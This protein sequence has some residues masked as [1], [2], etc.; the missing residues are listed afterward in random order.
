MRHFRRGAASGAVVFC[1]TVLLVR[2]GVHAAT[3]FVGGSLLVNG[4]ASWPGGFD[5]AQGTGTVTALAASASG[6]TSG[7][8]VDAAAFVNGGITTSGGNTV[9]SLV[10]EAAATM[11]AGYDG[12]AF[13]GIFTQ[14]INF[15][16]D[17]IELNLTHDAAFTLKDASDIPV[18]FIAVP[19]TGASIGTSSL[20]A[21]TY[22]ISFEL[23]VFIFKG[24]EQS[25]EVL[26]WTLTLEGPCI[27]D[28]APPAGNGQVN[29]DDLLVVINTWGSDGAGDVTG[30]GV[31]N[32]DDLLAVVNSWGSCD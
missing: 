13:I 29:V 3:T 21:G 32:V 5:N 15:N 8:L 26:D 24:F 6:S 25:T 30:N 27:A 16:D 7:G 10:G 22:K 14:D 12:N 20:T 23:G 9:V 4:S 19:E 18:L 17:P 1:A 11:P 31:V 28:I 2:A